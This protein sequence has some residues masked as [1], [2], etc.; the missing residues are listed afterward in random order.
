ML[1]ASGE[2]VMIIVELSIALK[3]LKE[4][5]DWNPRRTI[6]FIVS[7]ESG[8]PCHTLLNDYD[9]RKIVSYIELNIESISGANTS[10]IFCQGPAK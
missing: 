2:G 6:K 9:R 4:D 10:M 8:N 1:S 7:L 3:S 5:Y